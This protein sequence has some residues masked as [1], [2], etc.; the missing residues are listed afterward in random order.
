[1]EPPVGAYL[2]TGTHLGFTNAD[3]PHRSGPGLLAP[4]R[5]SCVTIHSQQPG[6]RE[7]VAFRKSQKIKRLYRGIQISDNAVGSCDAEGGL[8]TWPLWQERLTQDP[9]SHQPHIS[10]EGSTQDKAL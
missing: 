6:Q 2:V 4:V 8:E 3:S 9:G 7:A 1:M 5:D 10:H